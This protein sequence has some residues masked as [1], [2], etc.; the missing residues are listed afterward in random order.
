MGPEGAEG[1]TFHVPLQAAFL[2]AEAARAAAA[3]GEARLMAPPGAPAVAGRAPWGT[4]APVP[5]AKVRSLSVDGRALAARESG[6]GGGGGGGGAGPA[7]LFRLVSADHASPRMMGGAMRRDASLL[8]MPRSDPD[9]PAPWA[10]R[11]PGSAG[12]L[13][14][15]VRQLSTTL[16]QAS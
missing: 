15:G 16:V 8:R 2:H 4:L 11:R 13:E 6:A 7:R 1:A 12:P 10:L 3:R 9:V 5:L 14:L